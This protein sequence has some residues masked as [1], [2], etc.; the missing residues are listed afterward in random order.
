MNGIFTFTMTQI[1]K[2]HIRKAII[3]SALQE[4]ARYGYLETNMAGIAKSAGISTGNIYRYF[5]SK[6]ELF[7]AA[8][9]ISFVKKLLIKLRQRVIAYPIGTSPE[10]ISFD[11]SYSLLSEELLEFTIANRLETLIILEGANGTPHESFP[12]LLRSALTKNAIQALN[13]TKFS[14]NSEVVFVVIEEIYQNFLK[15]LCAI[16]R[17]F[18]DATDIRLAIALYS[19]YHLA[20]LTKIAE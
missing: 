2:E 3:K 20:G 7:L 18:S 19:K 16:L 10:A 11:S 5:S 1:L 14:D 6:E 13:L 8:I 9:P 15:A 4:F 12:K 17:Q